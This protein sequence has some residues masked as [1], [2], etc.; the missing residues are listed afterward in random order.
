MRKFFDAVEQAPGTWVRLS[1]ATLHGRDLAISFAVLPSRRHRT[2]VDFLVTCSGVHEWQLT[3]LDGG[4]VQLYSWRHPAARQY[5]S[6]FSRITFASGPSQVRTLVGALAAAH[7]RVADDWIPSDRYLGAFDKLS[8]RLE[9]GGRV[10]VKAPE[11]LARAYARAAR[12]CA[13]LVELA[14]A[15]RPTGPIARPRVLHFSNSYVV[16]DRFSAEISREAG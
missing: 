11:F 15:G 9:R 14:E 4:G 12:S 2:G 10:V 16:A 6:P 7:A 3:E 8:S 5:A 1:V 13:A